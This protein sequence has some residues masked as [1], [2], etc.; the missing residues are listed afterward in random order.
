THQPI[1]HLPSLRAIPNLVVIRPADAWEVAEAW[2]VALRRR[3]GPTALILTRQKVPILD[4]KA[5]A[6]AEGVARGGYILSSEEGRNPDIILIA[7]GSEVSLILEVQRL[8]AEEGIAARVVSMPSWELFDAQPLEY[9]HKVLPA[10]VPKLAVEAAAP[11]GWERYVG[12][13]GE[14][15]G[16]TRFGA[17]AT[18][19]VLAQKL[20]FTPE[21]VARRAKA[22][23]KRTLSQTGGFA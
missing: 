6:P 1:E 14:V 16:L 23:L 2:R 8:L 22:L 13:G 15:I 12:E 18:A 4:R 5:L 21:A 3:N 20:G 10:E 11:L 9:R 19:P 7:S 17:S